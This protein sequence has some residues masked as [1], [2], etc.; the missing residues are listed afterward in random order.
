MIS[1]TKT[2]TIVSPSHANMKPVDVDESSKSLLKHEDGFDNNAVNEFP[3]HA[4]GK[5]RADRSR[6]W[7]GLKVSAMVI[8]VAGITWF[9]AHNRCECKHRLPTEA[10]L[11]EIGWQTRA[12]NEDERF[13]TTDP[14]DIEDT[15]ATEIWSDIYPS[16]WVA[17]SDPSRVG[18]G[19]GVNLHRDARDPSS[20]DAK[21]EGFSVALMHQ[22]HCVAIIKHAFMVYRRSDATS[23]DVG[24][25]HID[26]C[27]EYLRQA[28]ICHGDLTLER[29]STQTYPQGTTGWGDVHQCRDWDQIISV[30]RKLAIVRGEDGWIKAS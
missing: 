6:L 21:T 24:I 14:G 23:H 3:M 2:F 4:T 27:V 30:I 9:L 28:I 29:P 12:L 18:Y 26:H 5:R 8:L 15:N 22:I 25:H 19:G 13:V 11:G 17:V 10:L 20:W 16:A 1:V 7:Y